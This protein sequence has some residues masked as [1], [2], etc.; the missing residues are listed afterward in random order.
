MINLYNIQKFGRYGKEDRKDKANLVNPCV[1]DDTWI[2]TSLGSIQVKDLLGKQFSAIVDG[3]LHNCNTGF[4][5]TG[6]KS[7]YKLETYEGFT[8][9]TTGDHKFMTSTGEWV[10][11]QNFVEGDN[12]KIHDHSNLS[13]QIDK[14]SLEFMNGWIM[15]NLYGDGTFQ[16]NAD[17]PSTAYLCYWGSNKATMADVAIS[18]L[19]ALS[20]KRKNEMI[21]GTEYKDKITIANNDLYQRSTTYIQRGKILTDH[22]E[23][24]SLNFQAGFLRGWFDADG[25][26]Q[27]SKE[28]GYSI[29]LSCSNLD[30]LYR[31]QRMALRLGIYGKI[32]QN[33]REENDRMLP[34]GHGSYKSYHCQAQHEFIISRAG[35][36]TFQDKINFDDP[37]KQKKLQEILSQYKRPLYGVKFIATV[38][39][40]ILIGEENVYDAT[41]DEVHA[42]DANGFYVH[43]C[44]EIPLENFELCNLAEVFPPRCANSKVY[45]NALKFATFYTST[46]SLL[47]THR[48]ETNAVVARNRRIG[49][50][51]SGVAQWASGEVPS[52]WGDM[53]Y[54]KM[55]KFLRYGYKVVKNENSLLAERAGIPASIRVTTVKP[56]GSI[57][58]LAGVTAGVHYPVSRYAI[59]RMRIG[60]DSP[61]VP[62]LKS[63]N[64]PNELDTYSDNTLVFSFAIDHGN[65]RPCEEVSPWEQFSLVSTMQRCYADNCVSATIYFDKE[66]DGPDVEKMLA[67]YIPVLKSVSMLPHSGHGYAQAPYEPIDEEKYNELREQ[68]TL[69]DF[70][71]IKNNVPEGSRFCSGDTCEL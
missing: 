31:A 42:F 30:S 44:G 16:Y 50:S 45:Y 14:V 4:F 32:Y 66:K 41:V 21:T 47:P 20:Y 36:K 35:L 57:S 3:Q 27:G 19:D 23:S 38:K 71:V 51:I 43:N 61:L 9:K 26:V 53:N 49:V 29:R 15:G 60:I 64:I 25:S 40:I 1:T 2:M 17:K 7:V 13:V 62:I 68:Y 28:K 69:P 52:E 10:E 56:S 6:T 11:L 65:V 24:A 8:V 54:T 67:M 58:L 48:P 12:I 5:P 34:D 18:R 63:A 33:R 37:E 70:S 22:V 55:T 46:V 59:R 39:N